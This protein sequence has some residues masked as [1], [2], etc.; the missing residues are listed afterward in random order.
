MSKFCLYVYLS[1]YHVNS[2]PTRPEKGAGSLEQELQMAASHHV[3][4]KNR[5]QVL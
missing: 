5:T 4:A 3:S 2:V 1:V